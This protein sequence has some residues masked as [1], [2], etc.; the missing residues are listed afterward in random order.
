MNVC[1][2]ALTW[3][4]YD[5]TAT[6]LEKLIVEKSSTKK[7]TVKTTMTDNPREMPAHPPLAKLLAEWKLSGSRR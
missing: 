6:P 7:R 3:R 2:A 4:D 5:P 1:G